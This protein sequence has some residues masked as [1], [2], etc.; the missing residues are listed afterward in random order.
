MNKKPT[1]PR[2]L[3]A[4]QAEVASLAGCCRQTVAK[5]ARGG[6]VLPAIEVAILLAVKE[7]KQAQNQ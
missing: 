1:H 4:T 3:P 7:L 2:P 5:W 6:E